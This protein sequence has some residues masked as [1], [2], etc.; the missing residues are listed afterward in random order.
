MGAQPAITTAKHRLSAFGALPAPLT[1]ALRQCEL[2][3]QAESCS[4]SCGTAGMAWA[5]LGGT[6]YVWRINHPKG[7][8]RLASPLPS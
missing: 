2:Q 8:R 6:L 5:A 4:V 3:P 1:L 7:C